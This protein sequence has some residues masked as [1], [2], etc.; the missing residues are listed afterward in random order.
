[1]SN[2]LDPIKVGTML[3]QSG[4]SCS[5]NTIHQHKIIHLFL[6]DLCLSQFSQECLPL[7]TD[8]NMIPDLCMLMTVEMTNH[9]ILPKCLKL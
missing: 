3:L 2:E 8:L 4:L 1:M 6:V 5:Q 9:P 7:S